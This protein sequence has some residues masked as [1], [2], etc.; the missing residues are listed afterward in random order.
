M[1]RSS[2]LRAAALYSGLALI[3]CWPIFVSFT[4]RLPS[5]TGD[6]GLNTWILWWTSQAVPLT[7]RWWNAPMFFP[8]PGAIAFSETLL[9]VAPLTV[10]LLWSG[11]SPVAVY[12][13]IFLLSIPAAALSA[14]ALAFRLTGRHDA[15]LLAGLAFGFSP[16]RAAQI[17]HLQMLLACWMPLGLL[18]LHAFIEDR[19]P[20]YLVFFAV[21]WLLNALTSGYLLLFFAVLVVLWIVWFVRSMRDFAAILAAI[22]AAS[23]P[24]VPLIAGYRRFHAEI[25]ATRGIAEIQLYSADMSAIWAASPFAS[26]SRLWTLKPGPEGELYPGLVILGLTV[27]AA[28]MAWRALPLAGRP[29]SLTLRRTKWRARPILFAASA[30]AGILALVS[31]LTGGQQ[32]QL[33]GLTISFTRPFKVLTTALWLLFFAIAIDRRLLDAWRRRSTLLFY[34]AAAFVMFVFALGP[35]GRAFGV[36]LIYALPYYWLMEVPGGDALRV[37]AR[38]AMLFVL[39]LG[40]A[41]AIGFSRLTPGVVR[42]GLVAA[43]AAAIVLEGWVLKMPT[44]VVPAAVDLSSVDPRSIVIELPIVDQYTATAALLRQMHHRHPVANGYS[45]YGLPHQG[46]FEFGLRE[47]DET[48]LAAFQQMGPVAVLVTRERG[49]DGPAR[50]LLDEYPA[51]RRTALLPVGALY[52]LPERPENKE[53]VDRPPDRALPIASIALSGP[54]PNP[55]ALQDGD[56]TTRWE[57]VADNERND[58]VLVTLAAACGR[59]RAWSSISASTAWNTR[60]VCASASTADRFGRERPR[61]SRSWAH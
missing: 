28:V 59:S 3:Y 14:H 50:K 10:P 55:S 17:P 37:P 9:S 46:I 48:V 38:F 58:Q 39:C 1:S 45:G 36:T 6:P 23:L 12:N 49:D 27:A 44:G 35:F 52:Q 40:Q 19:R 22:V 18:A 42:R 60:A 43:L 34:T 21:C 57:A 53:T 15:A 56:F 5:D 8:A 30:L 33:A 29:P 41:A 16:Y 47:L 11:V 20:R 13:L 7:E 51:A 24:L 26:F 61:D 2:L 54:N 25:G 31:F 32:F 4:S